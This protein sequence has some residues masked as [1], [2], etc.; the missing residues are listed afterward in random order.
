M[1]VIWFIVE[2]GTG[3]NLQY[4]SLN[5]ID[6]LVLLLSLVILV[7]M[8]VHYHYHRRRCCRN[9]LVITTVTTKHINNI[10]CSTIDKNWTRSWLVQELFDGYYANPRWWIPY[11]CYQI[12]WQKYYYYHPTNWFSQSLVGIAQQWAVHLPMM[13]MMMFV[14]PRRWKRWS[15]H[16][17]WRMRRVSQRIPQTLSWKYFPSSDQDVPKR[18]Q[19]LS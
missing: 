5:V 2:G 14:V 17:D 10:A 4:I 3:P 16:L 15:R 9:Y 7:T 8:S 12:R 6:L 1:W 13:T 18:L 19:S 11:V